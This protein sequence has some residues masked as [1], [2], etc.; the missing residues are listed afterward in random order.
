MWYK[1]AFIYDFGL[2]GVNF[3]AGTSP[4]LLLSKKD[5]TYN[6]SELHLDG[7][8]PLGTPPP[9]APQGRQSI[10]IDQPGIEVEA[11]I[12]DIRMALQRTK[13]LPVKSPVKEPSEPNISPIWIP[14]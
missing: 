14:R 1:K 6:S 13:T 12:K 5:N 10:N 2:K 8:D 11:A 7:L 4:E 9:P 3:F